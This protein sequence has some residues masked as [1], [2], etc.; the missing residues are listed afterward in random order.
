MRTLLIV[1]AAA[2]IAVSSRSTPALAQVVSFKEEMQQLRARQKQERNALKMRQQY[3][4][5]SLKG[6]DISKAV[7]LQIKHEMEREA[8]ALREQQRNELEQERDRQRLA[9]DT[10][11]LY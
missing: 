3:R 9:K 1:F 11:N 7:R 4:R 5:Q 6:Q 2:V 8:R 10:A